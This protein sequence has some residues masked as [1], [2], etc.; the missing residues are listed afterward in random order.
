MGITAG[1]REVPGEKAC[2]ERHPYRTIIIIIIIIIVSFTNV[3]Y[4]RDKPTQI[5]N[6]K[7]TNYR[8]SVIVMMMMIMM[9]IK[10]VIFNA[11][12]KYVV[13]DKRSNPA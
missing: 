5:S 2:D 9:M 13:S 6:T 4:K 8:K 7:T 10:T 3:H 12:S 11:I 1:S